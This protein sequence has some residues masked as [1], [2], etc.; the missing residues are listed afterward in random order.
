MIRLLL[1]VVVL[2][3]AAAPWGAAPIEASGVDCAGSVEATAAHPC[4]DPGPGVG[5]TGLCAGG[6][7]LAVPA[8]PEM[9]SVAPVAADRSWREIAGPDVPPGRAPPPLLEPPI[10]VR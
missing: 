7:C 1:V 10:V 9:P 8:L 6:A 5:S 2:A 4:S 3:A